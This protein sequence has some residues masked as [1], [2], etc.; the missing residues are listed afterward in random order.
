MSGTALSTNAESLVVAPEAAP[1]ESS[2]VLEQQGLTEVSE[3]ELMGEESEAQS[4]P[5]TSDP[6]AE[7]S[8]LE[9]K[10]E[11]KKEEEEKKDPEPEQEPVEKPEKPPTGYVPLK[12]VKEAR[13]EN[14]Y[15]KEQLSQLNAKIEELA[16]SKAE[17]EVKEPSKF[18]DFQTLS[19]EEFQDL[20]AED[21]AQALVY[22]K[23]LS[24][25]NE[26]KREQSEADR[27]AEQQKEYLE[28]VFAIANAEM[29]KAVPG[30]FDADSPVASEFRD[31]AV[32]LGFTDDM[33]YLT[34]PA[35]Q[36]I[37]PG[38]T[39]PLLLG[40]QAAQ[41]LKVLANARSAA[42]VKAVDEQAIEQRLRA[43][44][45]AEVLSKLKSGPAYKSLSDVPQSNEDRVEFGDKV[46]SPQQFE[47]LTEKEQEAYL[48]GY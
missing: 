42:P 31:Y 13:E 11:G 21:P 28:N 39:T 9:E 41:I 8:A 6:L 36:I 12:A 47:K 25:F 1:V 22:M 38:E 5:G 27:Q 43:K 35:T 16:K 20:A 3:A 29:E 40:E 46:L 26:Y 18:D 2:F 45:E 23:Q 37:L 32:G 17:P 7:E 30:I 10:A 34:N 15:L 19:D 48:A 4:T 44:I 33:F 14:R 24:E